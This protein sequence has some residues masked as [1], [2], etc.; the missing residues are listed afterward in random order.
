MFYGEY[1]HTLDEKGRLSIPS[2]FRTLLQGDG[3]DT[4]Y[5]VRGLDRCIWV[6]TKD[7]WKELEEQLNSHSF[8]D[9]SA[10][11]FKRMFFSGAS[12]SNCDRQGRVNVPQNLVEY[13]AIK[14][15]VVIVG[16]SDMFEIWDASAWDGYLK[17]SLET[18]EETAQKLTGPPSLKESGE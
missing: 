3:N 15:D 6:V 10:R 17:G 8:T 12:P 14:R 13:A 1:R 5:L 18:Y 11:A 4:F 16:S 7:K 9:T 2:R